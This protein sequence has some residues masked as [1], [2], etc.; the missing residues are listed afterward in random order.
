VRVF[1]FILFLVI[2]SNA[3][4]VDRVFLNYPA[5]VGPLLIV[6]YNYNALTTSRSAL[7]TLK[8]GIAGV[9]EQNLVTPYG[10]VTADDAN[11]YSFQT[12]TA[13]NDQQVVFFSHAT[14]LGDYFGLG[15]N[16]FS[17]LALDPIRMELYLAYQQL[18][19]IT[20][21]TYSGTNGLQLPFSFA[22]SSQLV[23]DPTNLILYAL[24]SP[25]SSMF[26]SFN[27]N[28]NATAT[29]NVTPPL[30][31]GLAIDPVS[32][33]LYLACQGLIQKYI[34][35]TA[36]FST[37]Y[38]NSDFIF[39]GIALDSQNSQLFFSAESVSTGTSN[40]YVLSVATAGPITTKPLAL[41][42]TQPKEFVSMAVA[43]CPA[44]ACGP[45]GTA[46]ATNE[47]KMVMVHFA[48]VLLLIVFAMI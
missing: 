9:G 7:L 40:L 22:A 17:S 44:G 2:V 19:Q 5:L 32:G 28:T 34:P 14:C 46:I 12:Y 8:V 4:N 27:I 47:A 23:L 21:V 48:F 30:T 15:G 29:V 42:S 3:Q 6:D 39:R 43:H 31:G 18:S 33:Y 1:L 24:P 45:C 26:Y 25:G 38:S 16:Q 41:H 13:I 11:V 36:V 10:Y 20:R 35:S 37:I